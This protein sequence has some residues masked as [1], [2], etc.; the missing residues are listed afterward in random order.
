LLDERDLENCQAVKRAFQNRQTYP[1]SE[2]AEDMKRLLFTGVAI[3]TPH[4][5]SRSSFP[6]DF[7]RVRH[8]ATSSTAATG[9]IKARDWRRHC[10]PV[11]APE[12]LGPQPPSAWGTPKLP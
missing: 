3:R 1:T 2:R 10:N 9:S 11:A 4:S 6:V 8:A 7:R 12:S 5:W